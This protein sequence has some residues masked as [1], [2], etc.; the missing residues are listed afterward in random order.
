MKI[1]FIIYSGASAYT[2]ANNFNEMT[3]VLPYLQSK[4][5]DIH[6]E[7]WDNPA[8]DWQSYDVA[9]LKTPWDYHR[10]STQ[11]T[12]W[13]Y[14]LEALNIKLL[15]DYATVRWNFDK[16]YLQHIA[17]A[18]LA[19]I[20]S[21]FINRGWTGQLAAVF[22]QLGCD[23]IIIK[24][25]VSGGSNNTFVINSHYTPAQNEE[26]ITMATTIDMVAQPFLEEITQ[27]EW[28]LLFF[29]GTYSH[30][31]LKKPRQ[32]DFRVQQAFGGTIEAVT[33][34]PQ[35]I[36]QAS[37]YVAQFAPN[38]LYARVDGVMV[39]GAFKLMELELIEPF[40]YLSYHEA[41]MENYYQAIVSKLEEMGG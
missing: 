9:L 24:P 34:S 18:G 25:C 39:N 28:S 26:I 17:D 35:L 8:V 37:G 20:P 6:A 4:G 38:T 32:G 21:V 5:L 31:I 19:I 10:K 33:P 16:H 14:K 36:A 27:G 12:Q 13:L 3:D 29:N 7:I 40:L 22:T 41:A 11:F 15:N 2:A 1:A 30:T 23:K